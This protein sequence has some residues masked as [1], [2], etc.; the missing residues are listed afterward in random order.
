MAGKV[1][2]SSSAWRKQKGTQ[3]A[4]HADMERRIMDGDFD[5]EAA[6]EAGHP[7]EAATEEEMMQK[8]MDGGN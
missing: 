1:K 4:Q 6:A 7:D 5:P 2:V 3:S 8:I